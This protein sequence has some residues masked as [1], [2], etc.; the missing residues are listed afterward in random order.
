MS[1][2]R[3][4]TTI[5]G[6]IT[7]V[8]VAAI[9][10]GL[11]HL[12]QD[13]P[14]P[15]NVEKPVLSK[16]PKPTNP[17]GIRPVLV[18][19]RDH[20]LDQER[21]LSESQRP[22]V[23]SEAS[24]RSLAILL[25]EL[26]GDLSR[27]EVELLYDWLKAGPGDSPLPLDQYASLANE[28][29]NVLHRQEVSPAGFA[30]LVVG[31]VEDAGQPDLVKDYAIQ[32]L[33]AVWNDL[34]EDSPDRNVV[35]AALWRQADSRHPSRSGTALLALHQLGVTREGPIPEGERHIAD[36]EFGKYLS[37]ILTRSDEPSA[38]RVTALRIIAD[39]SLADHLPEVRNLADDSSQ[40]TVVRLRAIATLGVIGDEADIQ[41]LALL[42]ED[43][44]LQSAAEL[45]I[46]K[47]TEDPS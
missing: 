43:V 45:A 41:P 33:R 37:P 3:T 6:I 11:T 36:Q 18:Q 15:K 10:I 32:H 35:T 7:G 26:P 30:E 25:K 1:E 9:L 29:M 20:N 22:L 12:W 21:I 8:A 19:F 24:A 2:S 14:P 4:N 44:L 23:S 16:R 28:V 47:L 46:K 39:R 38:S 40:N 34:N 31:L 27:A 42:K 17:G 5:F 13:D